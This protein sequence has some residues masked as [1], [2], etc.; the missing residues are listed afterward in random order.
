MSVSP[1]AAVAPMADELDYPPGL[2][3][4]S[5]RGRSERLIGDVIVDLGFARRDTVEQAVKLAREQGI[6]TGRMMLDMGALRHDQLARAL[7]ERFGVDYVDLSVFEID[8][9][10]ASLVPV[11]VAKRYHAVPVGFM[12]DR[13]VLLA[14]V[15]PSNVLTLDEISMITGRKVRPA[16]AAAEDVA[17]LLARLNRLEEDVA[18]F[19]EEEPEIDITLLEGLDDE[20]PVIKLVYA[21]IAQAVEQ[22]A[23]DI[24]C[25]PE[26]GDMRVLYRI[27]GILSSAATI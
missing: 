8:M 19:V 9:G 18:E 16:A 22:G 26:A 14:M 10:A 12:P 1:A 3:P 7:A 15:D 2:I 5:Q 11:D 27:D 24:H 20:A 23:S 6:P 17:A 13:S 25:D 4:P 21:L